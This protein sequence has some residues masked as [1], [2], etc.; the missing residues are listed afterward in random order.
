MSSEQIEEFIQATNSDRH[1]ASR[2]LQK[3]NFDVQKAIREFFGGRMP[4]GDSKGPSTWYAGGSRSGVAVVSN[5]DPHNDQ[6]V[7]L[8]PEPIK[9]LSE[10]PKPIRPANT[11]YSTAGSSKTRI[12]F[13]IENLPAL[14]LTVNMSATV[15][16]LKEF[17]IANRPVLAEKPLRLVL[18]P[19]TEL[20]N[21]N[22][23]VEDGKMKM[24]Q[25]Q[26]FY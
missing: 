9:P 7:S 25:I 16:E 15:G 3:N 5:D 2:Y 4:S 10:G 8:P 1:M 23:T 20:D 14:T 17:V 26:V 21:D 11:D 19:N 12:R 24:A 6:E 22:L 18:K 13:E